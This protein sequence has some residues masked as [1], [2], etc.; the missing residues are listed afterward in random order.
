MSHSCDTKTSHALIAGKNLDA[1]VFILADG[2]SVM[3]AVDLASILVC[4]AKWLV[5]KNLITEDSLIMVGKYLLFPM[6]WCSSFIMSSKEGQMKFDEMKIIKDPDYL[7]NKIKD[8]EGNVES[9][10]ESSKDESN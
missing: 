2:I 3:I 5:K 8:L 1:N 4:S 6:F 9:D 10:T 7:V